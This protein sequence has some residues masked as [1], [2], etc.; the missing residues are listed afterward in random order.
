MFVYDAD[1]DEGGGL[2]QSRTAR[3]LS[4]CTAIMLQCI[5]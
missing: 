1:H 5:V 4:L 3:V 2:D